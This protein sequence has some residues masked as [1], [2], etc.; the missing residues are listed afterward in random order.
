M[1]SLTE[2]QQQKMAE[3][4]T[5]SGMTS[6][7]TA[8]EWLSAHDWSLENAINSVF[9]SAEGHQ[10]DVD[11]VVSQGLRHRRVYPASAT[12]D[13][14]LPTGGGASTS[15]VAGTLATSNASGPRAQR[16]QQPHS[17]SLIQM[18]FYPLTLS[19]KIVWVLLSFA[20]TIFPFNLIF[21][22]HQRVSA[23]PSSQRDPQ[24]TAARFLLDYEAKHGSEHPAFFQGTYSQ[25][26]EIC[27]R[28]LR[29]LVVI[30]HSEEH[31]DTE[32]FCRDTLASPIVLNFLREKRF[33][34]WGGN[35]C[36]SEA[37]VVSNTLLATR[38]P[39]LSLIAPQGSSRMVVVDR[40]EGL[41]APDALVATLQR[42]LDRVEAALRSVR[43]DRERREQERSLRE[44]QE[45]AYNASLRADQEKARRAQEEREQLAKKKEEEARKLREI[46][47]RREA[48]RQR[49]LHLQQ[50]IAAEPP[51]ADTVDIAKI[52][53]RLPGGDRLVRRF[54]ATLATVQDLYDFIE[55]HDLSPIDLESDFE[56]INSYPRKV[57]NDRKQNIKEAGL[58]PSA[59]VMVEEMDQ[60]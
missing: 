14:L 56:V 54:K 38:Y 15:S 52:G 29:C 40:V 48:K 19:F 49:K 2:E 59:S 41:I 26:L 55:T 6:S 60:E 1:E 30:L 43:E 32:A 53:I 50:T 9:A 3:F 18:A 28:E 11:D 34:V 23:P 21:K 31:D 7:E 46:E 20:A 45:E 22:S 36:E 39:F 8:A 13:S 12:Q 24:A 37:F 58:F 10:N 42:Q 16:N 25:A 51:V 17:M 47:D 5:I 4:Q 35:I 33:L 27:K 44:Q 57:L